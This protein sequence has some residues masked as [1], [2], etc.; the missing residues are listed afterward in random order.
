MAGLLKLH[1]S[2]FSRVWSLRSQAGAGAVSTGQSI[3]FLWFEKKLALFRTASALV[4][5][6]IRKS[7]LTHTHF[8]WFEQK[9]ALFRGAFRPSCG[10]D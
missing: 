10:A 7:V 4:P 2:N 3:C 6:R 8:L 1:V 5:G 9:M